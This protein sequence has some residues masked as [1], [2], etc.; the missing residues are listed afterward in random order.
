LREFYYGSYQFVLV[1]IATTYYNTGYVSPGDQT[2]SGN[3]YYSFPVSVC[4][5]TETQSLSTSSV[6]YMTDSFQSNAHL[7]E[8]YALNYIVV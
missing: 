3:D 5:P 8:S 7:A 2:N 6:D 4:S 1:V